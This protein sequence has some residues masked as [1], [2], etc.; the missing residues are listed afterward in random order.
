MT[1]VLLFGSSGFLG[2]QVRRV[3]AAEPKVKELICPG[4]RQ[5]DLIGDGVEVITGLVRRSAPDAVVNCTGRLTGSGHDLVT[6][7]TAVTAKLIEAVATAAPG[8][9]LVRIGSASEYGP[10]EAGRAVREDDPTAPVSEYGVSHLAATRLLELAVDAGRLDGV[11]LRVFN[12]I[13]SGLHEDN[14]LGLAATKLRAALAAGADHV[15]MGSLGAY[16][17]FVDVRDVAW[18]V[19]AAVI[20]PTLLYPVFNVGSGKAVTARQAVQ[21]LAQA[22]GFTG[23]I[24]EKGLG[25][26]RSIAVSWIQADISRAANALG[27]VPVHDLVTSAKSIWGGADRSP[28][29]RA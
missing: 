19:H 22:A 21:A 14:L 11:V 26:A 5:C 3:L 15:T 25:P 4:R 20:T 16:R 17:D 23:E 27:W 28:D 9:R 18:A 10:V 13:G 7:N 6:A 2:G 8:A 1:R 12:P 24:R 29:S